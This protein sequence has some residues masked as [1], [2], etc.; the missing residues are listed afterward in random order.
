MTRNSI[1]L[2]M[3]VCV[4]VG[5]RS[6]KSRVASPA[7]AM[8]PNV[9]KGVAEFS[10][11]NAAHFLERKPLDGNRELLLFLADGLMS[12]DT[13]KGFEKELITSGW[14]S[15]GKRP[16]T[17]TKYPAQQQNAYERDGVEMSYWVGGS[18]GFQMIGITL[19][20]QEDARANKELKATDR[21]AP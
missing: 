15:K 2:V 3:L 8:P 12:T 7:K 13:L 20:K 16:V 5:C 17:S 4:M 18:D 9:K 21:S 11:C 6:E 19:P 14:K 1:L 10:I